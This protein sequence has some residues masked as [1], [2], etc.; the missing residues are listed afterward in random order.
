MTGFEPWTSVIGS[1]HSTKWATTTGLGKWNLF[2]DEKAK[3]S[4]L[5]LLGLGR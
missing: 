1:N 4:L 3:K 2:Q 5:F